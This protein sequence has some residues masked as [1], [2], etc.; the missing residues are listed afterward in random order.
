MA[1]FFCPFKPIRF[2]FVTGCCFPALSQNRERTS[3]CSHCH[4]Y[5]VFPERTERKSSDRRARRQH[6]HSFKHTHTVWL[7]E[8]NPSGMQAQTAPSASVWVLCS[9]KATRWTHMGCDRQTNIR[10]LALI[11]YLLST[12]DAKVSFRG[13]GSPDLC[14][15][16]SSGHP[17]FFC[18]L[19]FSCDIHNVTSIGEGGCDGRLAD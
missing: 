3:K 12:L 14:H 15:F 17:P 4:N 1:F 13:K 19:L 16:H 10:L 11:S 8:P 7:I 2:I 5:T 18:Q 6:T 9:Q